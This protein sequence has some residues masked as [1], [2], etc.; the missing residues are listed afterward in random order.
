M[1][2][3]ANAASRRAWYQDTYVEVYENIYIVVYEDKYTRI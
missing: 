3:R 1:R 2:V